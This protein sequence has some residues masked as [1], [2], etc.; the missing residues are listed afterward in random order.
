MQYGFYNNSGGDGMCS[1][2][3]ENVA[4]ILA[5]SINDNWFEA[6]AGERRQRR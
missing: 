2:S 3:D 1:F 6:T 4:K 5:A